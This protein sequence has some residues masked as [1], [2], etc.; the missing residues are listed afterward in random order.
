[1]HRVVE[2]WMVDADQML[3]AS[4]EAGATLNINLTSIRTHHTPSTNEQNSQAL[5][6]V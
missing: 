3:R 4:R 5:Q 1:M 6:T 2:R